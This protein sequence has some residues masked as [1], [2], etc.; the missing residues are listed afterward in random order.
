MPS[1]CR[2]ACV[3]LALAIASAIP[4]PAAAFD[5]TS[6]TTRYLG[7]PA[8]LP[9]AGQVAGAFSYTLS[10][11]SY[12]YVTGA[13]APL[14]TTDAWTR[15][16]DRLAPS[17]SYGITDELS[18]GIDWG[19]ADIHSRDSF[20]YQRA[21]LAAASA[22]IRA[23]SVSSAGASAV[24]PVTSPTGLSG[25]TGPSLNG[26]FP[27]S[28]LVPTG[29]YVPTTVEQSYAS[30]G[31]QNPAFGITWR[32]VDQRS[33][34]VNV[35]LSV[36][37]APDIF[38]A[39]DPGAGSG[40]TVAPGGQH[41]S[42]TA[43]VSRESRFLTLLGYARF[44]YTGQLDIAQPGGLV[45]QESAVPDYTLGIEG[46][47]RPS[48]RFAIN[49]GVAAQKAGD[50]HF[51]Y[52]GPGGSSATYTNRPGYDISPYIGLLVPL[53]QDRMAL[54]FAYQHDFITDGV[55]G[56][57]FGFSNRYTSQGANLFIARLRFVFT[58]L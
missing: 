37:Y 29:A 48:R 17:L 6:D 41:G 4:P 21:V 13:P 15:T 58:V 39:R 9:L 24:F 23:A 10:G 38:P 34:P 3:A 27:G 8:F 56:T 25:F 12:D 51:Q 52:S 55:V 43:A 40:G 47:A 42:V 49:F 50:G 22:S 57:P 45:L 7:D 19:W 33:A 36:S 44:G 18:I 35:D 30:Q 32:A 16:G 2:L 28:F 1:M 54:S 46:E 5:W 14:A 11:T 20:T 53:L 26:P 31:W